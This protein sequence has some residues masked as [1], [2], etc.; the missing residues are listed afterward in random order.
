MANVVLPATCLPMTATPRYAN[1]VI[2]AATPSGMIPTTQAN[3]YKI[4]LLDR[5]HVKLICRG[6]D[7]ANSGVDD[8]L[9]WF[10]MSQSDP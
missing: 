8:V 2:L 3:L 9:P 7:A 10:A 4:P 6:C 5:C 1:S